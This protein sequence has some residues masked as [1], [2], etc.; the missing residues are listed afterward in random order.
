L[1]K[2]FYK[3]QKFLLKVV[4]A[5]LFEDFAGEEFARTKLLYLNKYDIFYFIL[6][7]FFIFFF[8]FRSSKIKKKGLN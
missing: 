8:F 3:K 5:L 7:Y 2:Y 4:V 1:V 6:F